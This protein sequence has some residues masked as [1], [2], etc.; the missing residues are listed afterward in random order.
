MFKIV[1]EINGDPVR[2]WIGSLTWTKYHRKSIEKREVEI[3]N[4]LYQAQIESEPFLKWN[5]NY[6]FYCVIMSKMN[7]LY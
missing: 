3:D 6:R 1:L 7:K 2:E 5:T 4:L